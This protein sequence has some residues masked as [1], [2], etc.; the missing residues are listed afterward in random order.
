MTGSLLFMAGACSGIAEAL[1]VQP[2]DMVKTRH[3]LNTAKNQGV[4]QTLFSLYKEGGV[5]RWYRGL[6]AELIGMV[7]KSSAMY[8]TYEIVRKKLADDYGYGDITPVAAIAGF[9]AGIPESLIV[10]P[11]QVVKVR[12]QAKEHLGRYNNSVDCLKKIVKSEGITVLYVGLGPTIW[13]NC[14]WNTVYFGL[15]HGM[16][17]NLPVATTVA[18]DLGQTFFSGFFGAV[19]A[20]CIN[21]PFDVVKSRFQSQIT[22]GGIA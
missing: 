2:L 1:I 10:T 13:R 7:P 4:F 9:S 8:G 20:T 15:M 11:A 14:V 3:Q 18:G 22:E 16:K 17:K 6:A 19:F 12:L 21:I 5:R